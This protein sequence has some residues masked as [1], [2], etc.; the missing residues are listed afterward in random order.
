MVNGGELIDRTVRPD[1][2]MNQLRVWT[3]PPSPT[4]TMLNGA[5]LHF[6][7]LSSNVYLFIF[8]FFTTLYSLRELLA[9]VAPRAIALESD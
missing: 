9:M 6:R 5:S 1:E 8:F 4:Q 2:R 3:F 7:Q